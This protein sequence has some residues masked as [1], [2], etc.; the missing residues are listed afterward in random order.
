MMKMLPN[1]TVIH[2][3]IEQ[4]RNATHAVAPTASISVSAG[5]RCP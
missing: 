4:T 2:T 5:P 3:C 1:M